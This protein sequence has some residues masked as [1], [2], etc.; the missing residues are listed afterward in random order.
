MNT[1]SHSIEIAYFN[2]RA[3]GKTSIGQISFFFTGA[4]PASLDLDPG[5]HV[6]CSLSSLL[7][8]AKHV[9]RSIPN[10]AALRLTLATVRATA[11]WLPQK[12]P[13][14]GGHTESSAAYLSSR[15]KAP[16]D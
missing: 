13:A 9:F 14:R 5:K 10:G 11:R 6:Y 3:S 7:A 12:N 1:D 16:V 8:A 2:M 15:D 4:P